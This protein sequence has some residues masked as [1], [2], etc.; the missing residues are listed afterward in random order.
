MDIKDRIRQQYM[1]QGV[2]LKE[3][4]RKVFQIPYSGIVCPSPVHRKI[5]G[6]LPPLYGI[7]KVKS[8]GT[9]GNHKNL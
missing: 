3:G 9:V 8:I 5:K 1:Q 4:S 6:V 7:G 2:F